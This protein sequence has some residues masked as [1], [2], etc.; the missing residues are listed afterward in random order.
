MRRINEIWVLLGLNIILLSIT[1]A[2]IQS[3]NWVQTPALILVST[4]G[5][6][7]TLASSHKLINTSISHT[8]SSLIGICA[9]YAYGLSLIPSLELTDKFNELNQRLYSW[10]LVI[11]GNDVTTDTVP[12]SILIVIL[13]WLVSYFTSWFL[14]YHKWVWTTIIV[15]G[16]ALIINLTY[17]PESYS[18]YLFSF[19][20]A[21][22]ILIVYINT[23][24][25]AQ[26]VKSKNIP[27]PK[28][29]TITNLGIGIS[30]SALALFAAIAITVPDDSPT[31]L[32]QTFRPI[33]R[34]VNHI[35]IEF[36]RIFAAVPTYRSDS[37]RFFDRVLPLIRSVPK[38]DDT[39]FIANS[40]LPLYWPAIAYD[41]YTSTAWR[42]DNIETKSVTLFETSPLDGEE[43]IEEITTLGPNAVSYTIEMFVDSP[44]M[45]VAGA[46]IYLN[47]KAEQQIPNPT[48]YEMVF[49]D[50]NTPSDNLPQ[51]VKDWLHSIYPGIEET[52]DIEFEQIPSSFVV[53]RITKKLKGSNRETK[54]PIDT[55]SPDYY[56]DLKL[57]LEEPGRITAISFQRAIATSSPISYKPLETLQINKSYD[58]VS[59]LISPTEPALLNASE[60][61]PNDISDRYT[62]LP[63]TLPDRVGSLSIS[64]TKDANNTYEKALNIETY[65]R[66]LTYV[67][68]SKPLPHKVDV[69]DHFL[70]EDQSGYSD[71][72]ASAMAV[73]LRTLDIPTRVILGFGPGEQNPDQSGFT[74]RDKDNHVWPE[75]FF[76]NIGWVPFEPTPIYPT[77]VRATTAQRL[78]MANN[79]GIG[80]MQKPML[81]GPSKIDTSAE[82]KQKRDDL[83]GPLS[84]GQGAKER[85]FRHFGTP[86][87]NGGVIFMISTVLILFLSKLVWARMYGSP[88]RTTDAFNRMRRLARFLGVSSPNNQTPYEFAHNFSYYIPDISSE[89][90]EISHRF[91]LE[92]YGAKKQD[93]TDLIQLRRTWK[94]LKYSLMKTLR[95]IT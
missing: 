54:I 41:E 92:T 18:I 59:E 75:V 63:K 85:P 33:N 52:G 11:F 7:S 10:V 74:V 15:L 14:I 27:H 25:Y 86:L 67:P 70:F 94:S 51:D 58:V 20:S 79:S 4:L 76:T 40:R 84:G 13:T 57:A 83:G 45:M 87:G 16:S 29:N 91:V 17:I 77:R 42:V 1:L 68:K 89:I 64:L 95:N 31:P 81:A 61:I 38:S 24:R 37:I 9:G 48:D 50:K 88:N 47:P 8:A 46:P 34:Y 53:N 90:E 6:L 55:N 26:Y 12:L 30:I 36:Q 56:Q 21:V 39:V 65:L 35:R 66:Q 19:V 5:A 82:E 23:H 72:F 49:S 3:A 22:L 80:Q 28:F 93:S 78:A 43:Q 60:G 44:Y 69:V 71:Y 73:M 32:K 62:D 2:S